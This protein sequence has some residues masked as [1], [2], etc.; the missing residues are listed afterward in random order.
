MSILKYLDDLKRKY[1]VYSVSDVKQK[2]MLSSMD[3][4][5]LTPAEL[6]TQKY[7]LSEKIQQVDY[8]I[9][10][11]RRQK[12]HIANN[13]AYYRNISRGV[14]DYNHEKLLSHQIDHQKVMHSLHQVRNNHY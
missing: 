2:R 3:A 10:S 14:I 5:W 8:R 9:E 7:L 6:A 12:L 4:D 1:N 11:I 13:F